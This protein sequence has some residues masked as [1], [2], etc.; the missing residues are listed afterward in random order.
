MKTAEIPLHG[1]ATTAAFSFPMCQGP[2]KVA[3]SGAD[4]R[5]HNGQTNGGKGPQA[6]RCASCV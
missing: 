5:L 2:R 4:L 3:R 6:A 1:A